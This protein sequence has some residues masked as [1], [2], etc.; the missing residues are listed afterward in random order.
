MYKR[1]A[2]YIGD[3]D[4]HSCPYMYL[5]NP[6]DVGRLGA[7]ASIAL[8][9]EDITGAEGET[10]TA[11]DMGE[12]TITDAGDGG[13]EIILGAPFKF[14]PSNIDEWKDVY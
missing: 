6:I 9:N 2:E 14:D 3:D 4:A 10:F 5:W 7:Y 8:F 1:Q 12:Y 13:T 11:G